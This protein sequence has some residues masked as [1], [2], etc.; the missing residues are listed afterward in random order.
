MI[1]TWD[2]AQSFYK[3]VN[4]AVRVNI[5]ATTGG[6]VMSKTPEDALELFEEIANT[7][8]LWFNKRAIPRKGE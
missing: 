8:S 1:P 3:G 7:Q 6:T 4:S 2:L 5:D